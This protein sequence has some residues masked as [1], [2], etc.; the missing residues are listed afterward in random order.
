MATTPDT[1]NRQRNLPFGA[2]L[3]LVSGVLLT[4]IELL[5]R[6]IQGRL[7]SF[8]HWTIL[9]CGTLFTV[10]GLKEIIAGWWPRIG[11]N[12]LIRNRF[13]LPTEGWAFLMMMFVLF[14]GS[15]MGKSNPLMLVFSMMAGA[16][17]MNGWLTFTYLKGVTV[18]RT[19]PERVM[20]GEPFSIEVAIE[21]NKGWLSAWMMT[22]KDHVSGRSTNLAPEV[23]F[24][25]VPPG[26]KQRGH[27][28]L[29]LADRG[30]YEFG[31]VFVDTR[32][33]LGLVERGLNLEVAARLR[34]Y[35]RLGRLQP[36][37][38]RKLQNATE[39]TSSQ[40]A[41]GG[42]FADEFH[43]LREYRPGDDVRSIHWRTSAR[44]NE[45]MVREHRDSRDRSLLI[46][47]DTWWRTVSHE[48]VHED[49]EHALSFAATIC[50]DAA[51]NS[52]ESRITL[53]VKSETLRVWRGGSGGERIEDLLDAL[54]DV[55]PN[56][57]H[58]LGPLFE[59]TTLDRS[60][61]PRVLLLTARPGD[62]QIEIQKHAAQDHT[63]SSI[64]VLGFGSPNLKQIFEV[65]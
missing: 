12:T 1:S 8:G 13:H 65:L 49:F 20:A 41:Q 32:F 30:Q 59:A 55:L 19:L 53:A 31:P 54:A 36:D 15:L 14:I 25:R 35:P 42:I 51:R 5:T 3:S 40:I 7:G 46:L 4:A 43:R 38:K 60:G 47:L 10:W 63:L 39:Q 58:K 23:A 52:R 56:N 17:V 45:L 22:V 44:R 27:Y 9:F 24:I 64:Q 34:V 29:I 11:R 28:Q 62:A 37:W 18:E 2:V 57:T 48:Q 26:E 61:L 6:F 50:V 16:F 21:N 33:P